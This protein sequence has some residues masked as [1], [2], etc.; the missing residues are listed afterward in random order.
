MKVGPTLLPV[1]SLKEFFATNVMATKI[2]LG[3]NSLLPNMAPTSGLL[4]TEDSHVAEF[5]H[6]LKEL[7]CYEMENKRLKKLLFKIGAAIKAMFTCL[8]DT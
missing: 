2:D 1:F 6:L 3:L 7:S 8:V 4:E 5:N